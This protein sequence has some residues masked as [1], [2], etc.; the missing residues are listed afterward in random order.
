MHR[1]TLVVAM[2]VT[3]LACASGRAALYLLLAAK[4][5]LLF[6]TSSSS[7]STRAFSALVILGLGVDSS[8][9]CG[10]GS[11]KV[12]MNSSTSIVA[13]CSTASCIHRDVVDDHAWRRVYEHLRPIKTRRPGRLD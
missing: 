5:A 12:E 4:R 10:R 9:G 8:T 7:S 13:T 2:A 3:F 6:G 1:I 11:L